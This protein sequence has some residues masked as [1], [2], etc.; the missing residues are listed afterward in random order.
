MIL[1]LTLGALALFPICG[2]IAAIWARYFPAPYEPKPVY[3]AYYLNGMP[4]YSDVPIKFRGFYSDLG[5]R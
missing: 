5:P 1:F 4:M 2:C 3:I